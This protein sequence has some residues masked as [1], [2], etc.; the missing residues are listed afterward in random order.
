MSEELKVRFDREMTAFLRG[1]KA[2]GRY[3]SAQDYLRHLVRQDMQN[4][5]NQNLLWLRN[6]LRPG[7]LASEDEFMM[8]DV[9][10]ITAEARRRGERQ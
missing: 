2:A 6:Q 4:E 3:R 10:A 1:K 9:A 8:V 7:L 5:Q